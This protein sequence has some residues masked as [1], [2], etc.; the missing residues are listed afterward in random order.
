[1]S[2][3]VRSAVVADAE[4]IGEVHVASWRWAYADLM[5]AHVLAGL[6]VA[7]RTA[8]WRDRL[9][10]PEAVRATFVAENDNRVV[11]FAA[12]GPGRDDVGGPGV[13]ELYAVY[14]L[15]EVAGAGAGQALHDAGLGWLADQRFPLARLWV[16]TANDRARAFYRRQGWWPDGETKLHTMREGNT[17]H[18]TRYSKTVTSR[19]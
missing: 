9:S 14:V 4:D 7:D 19:A 18:E 10:D 13:G 6:S 8:S 5:P 15:A 17:I 12:V 3:V 2:F 1:V 16:F 11:G